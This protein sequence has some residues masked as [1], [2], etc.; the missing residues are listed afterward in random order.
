MHIHKLIDQESFTLT[1]NI[2]AGKKFYF[3]DL[4]LDLPSDFDPNKFN[5]FK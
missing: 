2:N 1:F 4:E 5:R 3:G